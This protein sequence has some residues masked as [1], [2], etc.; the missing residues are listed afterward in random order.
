MKKFRFS[1]ETVLHYREQML[2]ALRAEHAATITRVREQEREVEALN[3]KFDEINAEY[4]QKKMEGMTIADAVIFDG[5]LRVQENEIQKAL[6]VL[7]ECRRAEEVKRSEVIAARTDK[8]TVEKLREK[9]LDSYRKAMEKS[10]EQFI[11]EF[12]STTR[13][14]TARSAQ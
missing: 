6:R 10:E 13:V 7:E 3:Q 8:A 1:M 9:K 4:R 14:L 5:V 2:D 11:D 12:V